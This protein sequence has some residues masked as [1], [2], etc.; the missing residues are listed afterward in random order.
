[1]IGAASAD[2]GGRDGFMIA[3]ARD[4]AGL[5]ASQGVAVYAYRFSYVADSADHATGAQHATDIPF[6]LDTTRIRYGA[7]ATARDA[8]VARAASAYVVDFA[9]SSDPNAPG[10]PSWPR[11]D[12]VHD[13]IVNFSSAGDLVPQR[14][15]WGPVG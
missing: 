12:A 15:P 6:F 8:S 2:L 13:E 5:L 4:L 11:Y 3:G 1:M 10:L 7:E 14:D 9:L